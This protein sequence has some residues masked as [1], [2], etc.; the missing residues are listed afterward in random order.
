MGHKAAECLT[1]LRENVLLEHFP[2]VYP[3]IAFLVRWIVRYTIYPF[4]QPLH[5]PYN[6]QDYF[7]VIY[8]RTVAGPKSDRSKK[9]H[10]EVC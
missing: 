1:I 6:F 2:F 9:K 7:H 8:N 3:F 5:Y 4:S 10:L